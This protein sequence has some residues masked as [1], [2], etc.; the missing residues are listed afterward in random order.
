MKEPVE[1]AVTISEELIDRI[2]RKLSQGEP[3]RH[4][5]PVKGR[6]HIDRPLPFICVY[7]RPLKRR[8]AG[9]EKLVRGEASYLIGQGKERGLS[10]LVTSIAGVLS[11]KFK[12]FLILEIWSGEDQRDN[13]SEKHPLPKPSFKIFTSRSS[14]LTETVEALEKA[15]KKIKIYG[16]TP[17]VEVNYREKISPPGM[18]AIVK[19]KGCTDLN[20]SVMGLEI[21]PFYRDPHTGNPYPFVLRKLHRLLGRAFKRAF[22]EFSLSHTDYRP[23]NHLALGRRAV[24]KA[25]WDVD[26]KLAELVNLFDFLFQVTPVNIEQAWN[27]FRRSGYDRQPVLSYRPLPVD[28]AKLKRKLYEVQVDRIDDPTLSFLF[29]EKRTEID[30]KLTMLGDRGTV[31]F[32]YGSLQVYGG[33]GPEL[34]ELAEDILRRLSPYAKGESRTGNFNAKDF[35]GRARKEIRHYKNI[36]PGLSSEVQVRK[37]I[38]GLMV[39]HGNLLIGES[40]NIPASRV[41][42]LIQHEIGTH[43]LTYYNG[44]A[45]PFQQLYSGLAGYEALQEGLAVVSEYLVGGLSPARMR[46]LAGRVAGVKFL[47]DG[48]SFIETYRKLYNDYGFERKTAFTITVR[49]YRGGGLTK[50]AIY[51]RGLVSLLKYLKEGGDIGTLYIGKIAAAHVPLI[52]ELLWRRI[53]H[54]PP[55]RPRFMDDAETQEKLKSL[56]AGL[57]V[58]DLVDR[59]RKR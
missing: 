10:D 58:L 23:E 18:T 26:R 29:R 19:P 27:C 57:S 37:D 43:V 56:K 42:A 35:A 12:S 46:L 51:L 28:P 40:N 2:A 1:K 33:V 9:T 34:M 47:T 36:Y 16:M 15:L 4:S 49:I 21:S 59:R 30:R 50:D 39:S 44:K 22:F 38:V 6:I 52:K 17:A 11:A 14:P 25:V 45:Q 48:A 55:L 5:L 13:K 32:L 54:P 41:E 31:K 20:C 3:V 7:R 8:D 24:V 53:L